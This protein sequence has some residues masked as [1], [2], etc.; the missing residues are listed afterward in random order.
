V[1]EHS[2][3]AYNVSMMENRNSSFAFGNNSL[4]RFAEACS[5]VQSF[6]KEEITIPIVDYSFNILAKVA[7]GSHTKWSIV[8]DISN[9]KIH[10]RT[11]T[12]GDI[13]SVS[14]QAFRFDCTAVSKV[15][16][17]N[18]KATGEVN[19]SFKEF[20]IEVNRNLVEKAFE[21]S[22]PH[23]NASAEGRKSSWEYPITISC[24]KKIEVQQ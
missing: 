14:F 7:Q 19:N 11:N 12:F 1:Y 21:E 3:K 5:M 18:Q 10:F 9:K 16:D 8:Y 6:R 22:A 2:A 17:M 20:S 13:K 4:D 23:I 15:F 24:N